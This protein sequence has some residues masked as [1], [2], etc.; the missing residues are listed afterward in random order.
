MY[1]VVSKTPLTFVLLN[2]SN[3]TAW[4]VAKTWVGARWRKQAQRLG[5]RHHLCHTGHRTQDTGRRTQDP[6]HR[7]QD[8]GRRAQDTGHRTQDVN[9]PNLAQAWRKLGARMAQGDNPFGGSFIATS[10]LLLVL[11]PR[12]Q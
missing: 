6:G 10:L 2:G 8:T 7:T 4:A 1:M 9:D 3:C 5:A 12:R 11:P